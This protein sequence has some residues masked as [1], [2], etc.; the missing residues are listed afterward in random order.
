MTDSITLKWGTLK[1][2]KLESEAAQA[3]LAHYAEIGQNHLSAMA[4][5]DSPEQKRA[6]CELIDVAD[7]DQIYLSWDAKYVGKEEAKKYIME[8]GI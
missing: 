7:C 2:W 8:Y 6:I 1:G 3:A 5:H 4:Q